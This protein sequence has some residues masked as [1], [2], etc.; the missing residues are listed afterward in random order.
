MKLCMLP[1][2]SL[3]RAES[4]RGT[5]SDL[6]PERGGGVSAQGPG[7][8]QPKRL[9]NLHH[10][11]IRDQHWAFHVLDSARASKK[12]EVERSPLC[13]RPLLVNSPIGSLTK[14]F[15]DPWEESPYF[16]GLMVL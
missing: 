2:M 14:L 7:R 8:I 12:H 1:G 9:Y 16:L 11:S 5:L 15:S 13:R 3:D 10:R 4:V 6:R